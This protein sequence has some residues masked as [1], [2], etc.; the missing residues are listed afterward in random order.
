MRRKSWGMEKVENLYCT[1]L[2]QNHSI[3]TSEQAKSRLRE[4]CVSTA[5]VV[6][7]AP[8]YEAIED[9]LHEQPQRYVADA[10]DAARRQR[11]DP[12]A[13]SR[14]ISKSRKPWRSPCRVKKA[15]ATAS[16]TRW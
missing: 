13:A 5:I 11:H 1:A 14:L 4:P 16:T 12:A 7:R 6:R 8:Q 9:Q 10:G 2:V 15:I 3:N